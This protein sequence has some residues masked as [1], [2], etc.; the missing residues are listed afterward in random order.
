MQDKNF[1]I[2][3]L[4]EFV[5]FKQID[6]YL[7]ALIMTLGFIPL[8][9]AP[10]GTLIPYNEFWEIIIFFISYFI[11]GYLVPLLVTRKLYKIEEDGFSYYIG[12]KKYVGR[13]VDF[14][15]I[16]TIKP[17]V[18][19]HDYVDYWKISEIRQKVKNNLFK[20]EK[21]RKYMLLIL[22]GYLL[23]ISYYEVSNYFKSSPYN[24]SYLLIFLLTVPYI[25]G[26]TFIFIYIY[27]REKS[28]LVNSIISKFMS[29]PV[30][31][32]LHLKNVLHLMSFILILSFISSSAFFLSE[33]NLISFFLFLDKFCVDIL[34]LSIITFLS[35]IIFTSF[36]LSQ[37][38]F[39][40][41]YAQY[42]FISTIPQL[43]LLPRLKYPSLDFGY[44]IMYALF[45]LLAYIT[46]IF[47][48]NNKKK[49]LVA[50]LMIALVTFLSSLCILFL[51]EFL[52]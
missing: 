47:S 8:I 31:N 40:I 29:E 20:F 35:S 44:I 43:F 5:S 15:M 14:V 32:N 51:Y 41:S 25:A 19:V 9:I 45:V 1:F 3:N 6:G 33:P 36:G 2:Q 26:F 42:L 50:W 18:I 49:G 10:V 22:G 37:E 21:I 30:L 11:I 27:M 7:S 13:D 34:I 52:R 46:A 17:F 16:Y 38:E 28:K 24:N 23:G 12:D 48:T 39:L 4:A